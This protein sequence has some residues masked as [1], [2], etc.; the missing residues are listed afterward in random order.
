MAIELKGTKQRLG[1]TDADL[2]G[3]AFTETNLSGATFANV[4]LTGASIEDC[5]I[6]GMTI[7]GIVVSD[8]LSAYRLKAS[9]KR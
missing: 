3:S 5:Q 2:S 7:E 1:A 8:L 4:N 9:E 6:A